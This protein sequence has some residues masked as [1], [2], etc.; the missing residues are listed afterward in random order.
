[1]N[2]ENLLVWN[3]RGLGARACRNVMSQVVSLEKVSLLCIQ[4]T[5]LSCIPAS[6]ISDMLG[7]PRLTCF[8]RLRK[9]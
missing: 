6:I 1:M 4:E 8:A 3:V 9:T 7:P 5:K 2:G